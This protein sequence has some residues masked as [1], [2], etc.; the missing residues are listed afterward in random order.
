[1]ASGQGQGMQIALV[2]IVILSLITGVAAFLL[3][4]QT[5][6]YNSQ[7]QSANE[8]QKEENKVK[9]AAQDGTNTL[10]RKLGAQDQAAFG[11]VNEQGVAA[12]PG[13]PAP[14][15]SIMAM[16][17]GHISR[18]KT[19]LA[20]S[21]IDNYATLF[22]KYE[23]E[24]LRLRAQLGK[25]DAVV[26]T[27]D[28]E[29]SKSENNKNSVVTEFQ[30]A[31]DDAEASFKAV[32]TSIQN[33]LDTL[34]QAQQETEAEAT[35]TALDREQWMAKHK[36]LQDTYDGR[37]RT[38][39]GQ[40]RDFRMAFLNTGIVDESDGSIITIDVRQR[41][42]GLNIGE[43]DG[44]RS[45]ELFSVWTPAKPA[46]PDYEA[47]DKAN[48]TAAKK[49]TELQRRNFQAYALGGAKAGIEVLQVT[50]SHSAVARISW[51]TPT[52]PIVP[53]D[54]LYSPMWTRGRSERFAFIG[55]FDVTGNAKSKNGRD[56]LKQIVARHRGVVDCE[57]KDDGTIDGSVSADTDWFVVGSPP[58]S[59]EANAAIVKQ[60]ISTSGDLQTRAEQLGVRIITE[61]QLYSYLGYRPFT[62]IYEPG[63]IDA[64]KKP[65][66]PE[67]AAKSSSTSEY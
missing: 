53:G 40:L 24:V 47:G 48:Q 9:S 1:M 35:R 10:G 31:K 21:S 2:V 23:A 15:V 26:R 38:L 39:T 42:V 25:M 32:E 34:R 14:A 36:G 13:Q 22:L 30:K 55:S 4:Q 62:R 58:E 51:D 67:R 49:Q 3:H 37:I 43:A 12:A 8:V 33:Q 64:N 17:N 29:K 50:G 59:T 11:D 5:T 28:E 45:Q 61:A 18:A 20:D 16:V 41:T 44:L 65:E 52:D 6:Q 56:L 19:T 7:I 27:V 46:N 54:V 66:L 60:F 57:I 63:V